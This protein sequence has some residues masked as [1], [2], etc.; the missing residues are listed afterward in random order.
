LKK[1]SEYHKHA[2]ECRTLAGRSLDPEHKAAL[3]KMAETWEDLAKEREALVARKERIAALEI[4]RE[5]K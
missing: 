3:I 1:A 2:E 5:R 4:P